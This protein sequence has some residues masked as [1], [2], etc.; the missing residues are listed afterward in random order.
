MKNNLE[1]FKKNKKFLIPIISVISLF[2]LLCVSLVVGS[3]DSLRNSEYQEKISSLNSENI[4]LHQNIVELNTELSDLSKQ[5]EIFSSSNSTYQETINKQAQEIDDLNKHV[6]FFRKF[7]SAENMCL[8]E[9]KVNGELLCLVLCNKGAFGSDIMFPT[10]AIIT[11]PDGYYLDAWSLDGITPLDTNSFVAEQDTTFYAILEEDTGV[12]L[13]D[14]DID[15]DRENENTIFF[16][17]D[18]VNFFSGLADA[19]LEE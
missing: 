17:Q 16:M 10:E 6:E 13:P 18:K 19:S 3:R 1:K 9:F 2:A 7:A 4:V 15:N 5:L 8:L 11:I 14:N 12:V